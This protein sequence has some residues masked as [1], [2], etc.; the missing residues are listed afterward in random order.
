MAIRHRPAAYNGLKPRPTSRA[1]VMATG[2]PKPAA[3]SRK[4]PKEKPISSTCSR[5]SSVMDSTE[6]R[7]TSNW[8]LFTVS[9]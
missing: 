2:A 9:L 6:L 3:P 7:I 8:P 1:A 5:W 4:A